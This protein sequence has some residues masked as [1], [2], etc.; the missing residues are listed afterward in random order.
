MLKRGYNGVYHK[1]SVKHLG[2]YV[3]EFTGRY[4]VRPL[5]TLKRMESMVQGMDGKRLRYVDLI[6]RN[7]ILR[8]V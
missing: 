8:H 4:N 2:R 1:M 3:N 5:D 6:A 7:C